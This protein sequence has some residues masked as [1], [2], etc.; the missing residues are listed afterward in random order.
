[1]EN[2]VELLEKSTFIKEYFNTAFNGLKMIYGD[3]IEE[4]KLKNLILENIKNNDKLNLEEKVYI[5]NDYKNKKFELSKLELI[6]FMYNEK[7]IITMYG[8]LYSPHN[9]KKNLTA[10]FIEYLFSERKRGKNIQ[11]EGLEE[12]DLKKQSFGERFQKG[13]KELN[14]SL[15]G[16]SIEPNSHFYNEIVGPSILYTG[17]AIITTSIISFEN[18]L[19]NNISYFNISDLLNYISR[20]NIESKTIDILKVLDKDRIVSIK[21]VAN[22][23]KRKIEFKLNENQKKILIQTLQSLDNNALNLIYYKNNFYDFI[24]NTIPKN[25]IKEIFS[26]VIIDPNLIGLPEEKL[27]KELSK[28]EKNLQKAIEEK[29]MESFKNINEKMNIIEGIIYHNPKIEN[30]VN[31]LWGMLKDYVMYNYQ[32]FDREKRINE[33]KRE[34]VLGTDTDS[35]FILLMNYFNW[36]EKNLDIKIENELYKKITISNSIILL[37]SKFIQEAMDKFTFDCNVPGDKQSYINFKSEY[38]YPRIMF[39]RNKKQY[40][41]IMLLQEGKIIH[42][43][44]LDIKG[45][46]IRKATVNPRTKKFFSDI[47]LNDIL[48]AK[49]VNPALILRKYYEFELEIRKSLMNGETD[50]SKPAKINDFESYK[51]PF[52]LEAVRGCIL[53]NTIYPNDEIVT[54][55][56]VNLIKLKGQTISGLEQIYNTDEFKII[57]DLIFTSKLEKKK[58]DQGELVD[59]E[60]NELLHYGCSVIAIPKSK[61]KI[62]EW[63]IPIIDVDTIVKDN[64]A[65]G[66]LLLQSIDVLIQNYKNKEIY[67][68]F[69]RF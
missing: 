47:L 30:A 23:L 52:R 11:F 6:D 40:G 49:E 44:K 17:Y 42:P 28:L 21:D 9:K 5:Q 19:S 8:V 38:F 50:F 66:N 24:S 18:F 13:I 69:I 29:D 39:T 10:N 31:T 64:I 65:N 27:Q 16:V 4:E 67:S 68:N 61:T 33:L 12:K 1:M 59:V 14:N 60:T 54:P 26:T 53:W 63:I 43:E 35:N 46:S 37:L 36:V 7:P 20:I 58:N 2:S 3:T 41:G 56:K 22:K 32:I 55:T 48:K 62:P 34:T 57:K 15:F 25:L 51:L 45:L